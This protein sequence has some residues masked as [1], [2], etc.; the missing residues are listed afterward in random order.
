MRVPP[1]ARTRSWVLA[2]GVVSIAALVLTACGS[3]G[4]GTA[5]NWTPKPTFS[6]EGYDPGG[7]QPVQPTVPNGPPAPPSSRHGGSSAPPQKKHGDPAVV[8]TKLTTPTGI[9]I[10]PDNTA[11]VGERTTGRIVR[12][13]PRP[14]QPVQTV[15]T[16]TGL[17]TVGGG[18]LLDLAISPN[19]VQDNL[20]FAYVTT[21]TDNRV[22]AFTLKGPVTTVIGGIPR[23]KSDNAGR[24]AFDPKGNLLVATGDAGRP[25]LADNKHSLAGKILRVT[26]IGR[27][28]KGNPVP[29][30]AVYASGFR[31]T[32]G[33]CVDPRS[34]TALQTSSDPRSNADPV[35]QIFAGH[36]YGWPSRTHDSTTPLATLPSTDRSP[37]GC[38]IARGVL[39]VTSLNGQLVLASAIRSIRGA[40]ISL[41]PYSTSLRDKY[42][43]LLTVV[44]AE[45]GALWLTTS[46]RDGHGHPVPADERVLRIVPSAGGGKSKV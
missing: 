12:V 46:N 6:G 36:S 13:Q 18:G 16:L 35:N 39:F 37:G 42:G 2:T 11:L 19:Y 4:P 33:L 5:P 15:R 14:G 1:V 32:A 31:R 10:L 29:G 43:R 7:R 27:A 9:A 38:A 23:G 30:S 41:S 44:A 45:D 8:A 34:G 17:S 28:A 40:L 3:P 26:D 24:I 25:N 21:R 20:I 22:V